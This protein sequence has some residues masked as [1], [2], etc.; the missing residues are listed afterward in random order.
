MGASERRRRTESTWRVGARPSKLGLRRVICANGGGAAA[1][2]SVASIWTGASRA[3]GRKKVS[4]SATWTSTPK[5]V[6]TTVLLR[7]PRVRLLA[8]DEHL[9]WYARCVARIPLDA[10]GPIDC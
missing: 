3:P 8:S 10:W 2:L 1:T 4:G 6:S 9:T 5:I 7:A